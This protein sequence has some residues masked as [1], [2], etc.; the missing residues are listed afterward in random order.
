VEERRAKQ[1]KIERI[2]TQIEGL[3]ERRRQIDTRA[4]SIS[5]HRRFLR[6]ISD[7]FSWA[8]S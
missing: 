6:W 2:N 8:L 5:M 7:M 3:E 4:S 1:T